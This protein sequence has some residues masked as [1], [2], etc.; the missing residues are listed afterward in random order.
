MVEWVQPRKNGAWAGTQ[1]STRPTEALVLG[2]TDGALERGTACTLVF[3]TEI[4][5]IKAYI[6]DS[7]ER[8]YTG[9]NIYILSNSRNHQG[10]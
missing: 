9:R 3:Q 2:C 6:I 10:P 5:A 7:I 8:G 4:H 1:M